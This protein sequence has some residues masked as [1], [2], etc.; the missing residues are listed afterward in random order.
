MAAFGAVAVSVTA[1]AYVLERR[2]RAFA[3]VFA[4][5]CALSSAY[6]F[7]IGSIPFGTVEAL[8][9]L[10]ALWRFAG[11]RRTYQSRICR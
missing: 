9:S 10:A 1:M 7:T 6:G 11:S 8:W 5:G 4:L 2:H 3:A